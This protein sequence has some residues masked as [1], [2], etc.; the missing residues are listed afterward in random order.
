[1]ISAVVTLANVRF[2]VGMTDVLILLQILELVKVGAKLSASA[3][4]ND[5]RFLV[6]SQGT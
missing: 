2:V 5:A 1:V 6:K 4:G 3:H